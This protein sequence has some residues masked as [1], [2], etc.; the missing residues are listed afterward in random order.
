MF[1][2]SDPASEL[3]EIIGSNQKPPSLFERLRLKRR[4]IILAPPAKRRDRR[5]DF[6]IAAFGIAIGLASAMF[7]WYIFFNPDKFGVRAM[8][9]G[10]D[11]ENNQPVTMA[12]GQQVERVGAPM[13]AEDIPPMQLDLFATG[14]LRPD[15]DDVVETPESLDQP[16]PGPKLNFTLVHVANGRAMVQDGAGF[17]VVQKGSILPDSSRVAAIEQ[18]AGKWVLVTS[19]EDVVEIT[20]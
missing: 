8:K 11:G 16:F 9:F 5:S 4:T 15:K 17:W 7:P 3:L 10:G 14:S 18:R 19:R 12:L 20:H 13:S 6:I 1:R 2:R